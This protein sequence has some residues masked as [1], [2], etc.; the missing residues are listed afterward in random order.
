[1]VTEELATQSHPHILTISNKLFWST[2]SQIGD[3]WG[4]M[5]ST[6]NAS[7]E[8]VQPHPPNSKES[9]LELVSELLTACFLLF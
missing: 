1:M 5:E 7:S 3:A 9:S 4:I 2:K 8:L 6:E